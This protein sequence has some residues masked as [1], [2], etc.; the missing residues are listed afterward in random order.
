MLPGCLDSHLVHWL[1]VVLEVHLIDC[2]D[3]L[4]VD[5]LVAYM[6]VPMYP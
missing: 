6:V 1:Y 3:M 2:L 4:L 5:W